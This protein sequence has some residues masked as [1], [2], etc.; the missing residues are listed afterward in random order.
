MKSEV[1][2]DSVLNMLHTMTSMYPALSRKTSKLSSPENID[3]QEIALVGRVVDQHLI[4]NMS[5]KLMLS[6]I[7]LIFASKSSCHEP[8]ECISQMHQ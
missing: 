8:M 5:T 7:R 4:G 1:G 3:F 2:L 6:I